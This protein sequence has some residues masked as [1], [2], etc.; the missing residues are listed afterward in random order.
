MKTLE[1]NLN[2]YS[3]DSSSSL[4]EVKRQLSELEQKERDTGLDYTAEKDGLLRRIR[5]H[6]ASNQ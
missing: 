4:N 1:S 3:K 2:N 5:E 6:G